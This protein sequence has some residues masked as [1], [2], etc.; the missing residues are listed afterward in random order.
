MIQSEKDLGLM[1]Y[2]VIKQSQYLPLDKPKYPDKVKKPLREFAEFY[3]LNPLFSEYT[4]KDKLDQAMTDHVCY[5][6]DLQKKLLGEPISLTKVSFSEENHKKAI[7]M[8]DTNFEKNIE[9]LKNTG[10]LPEEYK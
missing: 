5:S 7:F 1:L 3:F 10:D 8:T 2:Y 6:I 4:L 9:I